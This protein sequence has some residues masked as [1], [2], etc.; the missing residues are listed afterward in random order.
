MNSTTK[1]SPE[2]S[3]F[4]IVPLYKNPLILRRII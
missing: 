2:K 3:T 1:T 4:D